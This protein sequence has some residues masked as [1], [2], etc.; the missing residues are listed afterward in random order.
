MPVLALVQVVSSL[1]PQLRR[2][3][4]LDPVLLD[5]HHVLVPRRC[6][7]CCCLSPLLRRA[8]IV[9]SI[10]LQ[11]SRLLRGVLGQLRLRGNIEPVLPE[12]VHRLPPHD[13]DLGP[14]H[15]FIKRSEQLLFVLLNPAR[16]GREHRRRAI[17]VD[18]QPAQ[19]ISLAVDQPVRVGAGSR[20]KQRSADPTSSTET[21]DEDGFHVG[22]A[23]KWTVDCAEPEHAHAVHGVLVVHAPAHLLPLPVDHEDRVARRCFPEHRVD[24]AAVDDRVALV[25]EPRLP[26][27]QN[28]RAVP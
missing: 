19:P 7:R 24:C 18:H 1:V 27:C 28:H 11:L 4:E 8:T 3:R 22:L 21:L 26:R 13:L 9:L 14:L 12:P 17:H 6:C 25:E 2:D 5:L 23:R 15:R 10:L 20:E 16:R